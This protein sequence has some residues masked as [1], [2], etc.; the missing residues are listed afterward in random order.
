MQIS[1]IHIVRKI[2]FFLTSKLH[3]KKKRW[4][5]KCYVK[6]LK[7]HTNLI[8]ILIQTNWEKEMH[9]LYET[10]GNLNTLQDVWWGIRND[11][12]FLV[13]MIMALCCF[14]KRPY[15]LEIYN[16]YRWNNFW[17][18]FKNNMGRGGRL[19]QLVRTWCS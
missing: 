5:R 10:T 15:L 9:D 6:K 2:T 18:L 19:A 13:Y 17:D 3:R 12:L 4:R 14:F 8:C 1:K 7:R 11:S 16:I